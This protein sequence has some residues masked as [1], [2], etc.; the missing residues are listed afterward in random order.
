MIVGLFNS[1]IIKNIIYEKIHYEN[2][3]VGMF[4]YI[5]SCWNTNYKH[6]TI[7]LAFDNIEALASDAEGGASITCC[8]GLWGECKLADGS[9]GKGPLVKCEF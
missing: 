9:T 1:L 7:G 4:R 8:A 5:V 3:S 2:R 6:N